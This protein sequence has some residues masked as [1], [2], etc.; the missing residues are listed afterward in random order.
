MDAR[1]KKNWYTVCKPSRYINFAF[2]KWMLFLA[3]LSKKLCSLF[4][5]LS[6]C[7]SVK[8][9]ENHLSNFNQT[10]HKASF[11]KNKIIFFRSKDH[12]LCQLEII[13]ITKIH[14]LW[15]TFSPETV[16][17]STH[18]LFIGTVSQVGEIVHGHFVIS[19]WYM[20]FEGETT[21]IWKG[22]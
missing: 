7:V 18:V 20:C 5:W 15:N 16:C 3:H 1:G 10:W 14:W 12:V 11:G 17:Q 4:V 9:L 22:V 21:N 2:I 19:G 13:E 6:V 8:F